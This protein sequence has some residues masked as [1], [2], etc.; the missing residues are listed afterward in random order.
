LIVEFAIEQEAEGKSANEAILQAARLRLRPIV[1]TSLAFILG[2][3]PL[4]IASGAGA[5]SRQAV[6][7]GVIGGM[8]AVTLLGVFFTPVF[9]LSAR[10]WLT[11]RKP[12]GPH[13]SE[14]PPHA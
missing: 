14:E 6:G 5:A 1:M 9:Y 4:F 8:I 7:T 11:R 3:I 12:L 13:A 2:M 10:R